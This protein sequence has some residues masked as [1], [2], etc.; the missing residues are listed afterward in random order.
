VS[1]AQALSETD[2]AQALQL[3]S[4]QPQE[5]QQHAR[6][7]ELRQR[8]EAAL[9]RQRR[10][11]LATDAIRAAGDALEK[12]ELSQG[13]NALEAAQ[14]AGGDSQQLTAAIAEYKGRCAQVA[15]ELLGAAIATATQ[16]I[17]QGDRPRAADALGRVA[18]AAEFADAGVQENWKRL[19]SEAE[20]SPLQVQ[21]PK[22]QVQAKP[23]LI[24]AQQPAAAQVAA[25]KKSG[26]GLA[27]VLVLLTVVLIGAAGGG[28]WWWSMRPAPVVPMG[29][30]EL[31]ATPY[32]EV[33]SVIPENGKA[34]PLPA[35]D[36]WTP[37]R[38]DGIPAGKYTVAFKGPD[39]STQSQQCSA[40]Q[41]AQVCSIEL[42]PIDDHAIDEIVG[43]AK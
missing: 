30:L 36:H 35:G 16:A 14:R 13:L 27:L 8:L 37:L 19:T 5:I 39:G 20:R 23:T 21:T 15:N 2:T 18:F 28:Y 17:Q 6:V 9:E 3:L 40:D 34:L 4:N 41:S 1:R 32:A 24:A 22:E 26:A 38:L 7:C 42:K 33:L 25:K 31:N 29:V 12:R 10:E 11:R 43:G